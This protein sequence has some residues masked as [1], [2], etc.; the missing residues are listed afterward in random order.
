MRFGHSLIA[1]V[2]KSFNIFG[3]EASSILLLLGIT[4]YRP[5]STVGY[6]PPL[7]IIFH[8]NQLR[9]QLHFMQTDPKY[10]LCRP[11]LCRWPKASSH[12]TTSTIT[13]RW[14]RLC[15]A[16]PLK[17][18]RCEQGINILMALMCIQAMDADMSAELTDHLFQQDDEKFGLDLVRRRE[19]KIQWYICE[20]VTSIH[21]G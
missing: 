12:L 8:L 4:L 20:A 5:E 2:I 11:S 21:P 13:S 17:R 16:L 1:G 15:G 10:T 6:L 3:S 18:R 9:P 7:L 19:P 14:S